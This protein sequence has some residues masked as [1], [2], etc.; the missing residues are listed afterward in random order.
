M[1][2]ICACIS[3][4]SKKFYYS[5]GALKTKAYYD[6]KSNRASGEWKTYN[7]SGNLIKIENNKNGQLNGKST[8]YYGDGSLKL[9]C[10]YKDGYC[11][12]EFKEFY[13][14]GQEKI[15]GEYTTMDC[16]KFIDRIPCRTQIKNGEWKFFDFSGN[17]DSIV[18][19]KS[20]KD[21]KLEVDSIFEDQIDRHILIGIDTIIKVYYDKT[22]LDK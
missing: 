9:V 15:E 6:K 2:L 8:E 14:N 3:V 13:Q 22:V 11:Q 1:L 4:E 12:G 18:N 7:D 10:Q 16:Q 17:V 19:Y 20:V 5:D 21:I